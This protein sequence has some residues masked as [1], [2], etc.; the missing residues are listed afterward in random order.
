MRIIQ[1]DKQNISTPFGAG[2]SLA[3][4]KK[5]IRITA[6]ALI[7]AMLLSLCGCSAGGGGDN[8]N[9]P[10]NETDG[11][12]S[13]Q[14]GARGTEN[15]NG[16]GNAGDSEGTLNPADVET[17]TAT[18]FVMD[19]VLQETVYGSADVTREIADRL[20]EIETGQLS[21]REDGSEVAQINT[22]C[23]EGESVAMSDDFYHWTEVSLDLAKNSGGV[24]DPT[25]GNL[26][27]LWNIEGENPTVPDQM[28]IDEALKHIGYEYI[29][30]EETDK[31]I[32]MEQGCTLDL[33]AVGKGIACD[34]IRDYLEGQ[35]GVS[36]AVIAVGGSILA[37]GN[38]P[39]GTDWN[40]AIQD[41]EGEEGE[42]MGV[43]SLP[44]TV[45]V[46]TSGDYEKYF[47]Q[48]G[49]RYHHILDPSTGYPSESGLS[50]VTVV[51]PDE[52][53]W[54]DYAGLLS[55]GL[56]TACFVLG[57]EKGMALLEQYGMEGIFIDKEQRVT[58][59]D[60]LKDSFEILNEEY[61]VN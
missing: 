29:N 52:G 50:S 9:S 59:T 43:L 51:C 11:A 26:T 36:G 37:Y 38:K 44:G 30:I 48:D 47:I 56:C 21:W 42:Y 8:G 3:L 57:E 17:F 20:S 22:R 45:C 23:N 55:D 12:A 34:V 1:H 16:Q 54:K 40:V 18:N 60:G 49:K 32:S 27:R 19:T 46:S 33:G 15:Q 7:S 6:M 61:E 2:R 10:G 58:I 28:E 14:T 13:E 5:G 41:P 31:T 4:R 25:I 35:E 53:Q 24:F 39:D